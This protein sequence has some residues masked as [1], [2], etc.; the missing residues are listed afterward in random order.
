LYPNA[1]H[2]WLDFAVAIAAHP[3]TWPIT[4]ILGTVHGT[5]HAGAVQNT[6]PAHLAIKDSAFANFLH[7]YDDRFKEGS[8]FQ[9]ALERLQ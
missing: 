7:P 9:P 6:L 2:F 5:G 4:Q 8:W 3:T 1:A